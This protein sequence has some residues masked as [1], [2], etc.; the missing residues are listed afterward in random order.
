MNVCVRSIIVIAEIEFLSYLACLRTCFARNPRFE[1]LCVCIAASAAVVAEN[2][3]IVP[4]HHHD[5]PI[6]FMDIEISGIAKGRIIFE[7]FPAA[8]SKNLQNSPGL[9]SMAYT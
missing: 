4:V 7:V 8:L 2:K 3:P 1:A 5:N 9:T 6:V